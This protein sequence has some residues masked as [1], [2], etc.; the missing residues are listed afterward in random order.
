MTATG[1]GN[2]VVVTRSTGGMQAVTESAFT[3]KSSSRHRYRMDGRRL[4][5]GLP[6]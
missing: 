2:P 6:H 5:D 1:D 4:R 3:S